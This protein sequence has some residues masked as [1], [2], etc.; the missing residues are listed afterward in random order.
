MVTMETVGFEDFI[1]LIF[2]LV[3][4]IWIGSLINTYY[5]RQILAE[6]KKTNQSSAVADVV[7]PKKITNS[8]M[9]C[10]NCDTR[11]EANRSECPKCGSMNRYLKNG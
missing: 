6:I 4:G 9:Y 11:L 2:L 3:F 10:S 7:P 8:L 5:M 1:F